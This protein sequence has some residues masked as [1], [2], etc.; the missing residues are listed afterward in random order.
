MDFAIAYD[1]LIFIELDEVPKRALD[2]LQTKRDVCQDLGF[3]EEFYY[4]EQVLGKMEG[5][6]IQL[7]NQDQT[8]FALLIYVKNW[9]API[10]V[11]ELTLVFTS[12]LANGTTVSTTSSK[13][14]LNTP[15]NFDVEYHRNAPVDK[16]YQLHQQHLGKHSDEVI[17]SLDAIAQRDTI[18]QRSKL[19]VE[20][21]QQRGVYIPIS[22]NEYER[23][24]K[25]S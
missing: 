25:I 6:G 8:I 5:Y 20:F 13:K 3:V 4:T 15:S 7:A 24:S 16:L 18:I 22:M 12:G 17:L 2:A 1:S 23:L 19:L 21:H 11:K 9:M 10:P 14:R